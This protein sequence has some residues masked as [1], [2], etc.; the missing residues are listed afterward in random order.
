MICDRFAEL[1]T[2]A[3]GGEIT[4]QVSGPETF[5][6]LAQPEPKKLGLFQVL[7]TY[8]GFHTGS[9]TLLSSLESIRPD[10]SAFRA[11]NAKEVVRE[12]YAPQTACVFCVFDTRLLD[13]SQS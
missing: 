11:S 1:L 8:L 12:M 9:A 13:L 7:C 5:R 6:P 2:E 10:A 3:S 4:V